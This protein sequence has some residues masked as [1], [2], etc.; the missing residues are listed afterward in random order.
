METESVNFAAIIGIVGAILTV[1]IKF[2]DVLG[3]WRK[4]RKQ[5]V[6]IKKEIDQTIKEVEFINGWL[7]AINNASTNQEGE[8]RRR[9]ALNRLDHLMSNYQ[10]YCRAET[11][12]KTPTTEGV[13]NKWFYVI[14]TFFGLAILGLFIDDKDNWSL[15]YFQNNMDTDTIIGFSFILIVWIY[16]LLNS[17]FMIQSRKDKR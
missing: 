6:K 17:H 1:F 16:F 12:E 11:A 15:T 8:K 3:S 14:S 4:S 13:S 10:H 5:D 9:I 2:F 7:T